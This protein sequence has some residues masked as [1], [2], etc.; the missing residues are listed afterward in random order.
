[1]LRVFAGTSVDEQ[2]SVL[3]VEPSPALTR[4]GRDRHPGVGFAVGDGRRL[5]VRS[6][7]ADHVLIIEVLHHVDDADAV[8][9]EALRALAPGGSILI[10]ESEFSGPVG[11]VR[12]WLERLF[13]HGVWPR[14]RTE[15]LARLAARGLRGEVLEHEGFVIRAVRA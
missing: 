8:I 1:M 13:L 6:G 3:V 10:E 15:L 14:T 4:R 7:S 9:A 11:R 12:F 5:P 2:R